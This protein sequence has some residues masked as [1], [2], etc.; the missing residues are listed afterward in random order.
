LRIKSNTGSPVPSNACEQTT[1]SETEDYLV[2]IINPLSVNENGVSDLFEMN[3]DDLNKFLTV[4][5]KSDNIKSI[6]I[7]DV[8]G[9]LIIEN[10][11]NSQ[12]EV[13]NLS[14]ISDGIYTMVIESG[15]HLKYLKF[16]R[17]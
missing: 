1:F 8:T 9:K 2:N 10:I 15:N 6:R 16:I 14:K 3:Y 13:I 11:T 7:Y 5:A 12:N 17:Y 4:S